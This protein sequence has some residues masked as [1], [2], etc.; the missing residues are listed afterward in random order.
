[1]A[2]YESRQG[3]GSTGLGSAKVAGDPMNFA[4][5][6]KDIPNPGNLWSSLLFQ[7]LIFYQYI[8][9]ASVSVV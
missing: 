9:L 2:Q 1:M 6:Q 5:Q 3:T 7:S 4:E 8:S